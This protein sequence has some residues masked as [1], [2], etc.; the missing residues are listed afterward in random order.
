MKKL[1]F[2]LLAVSFAFGAAAF[3]QPIAMAPVA[4]QADANPPLMTLN[5]TI[6]ADGDK[7]T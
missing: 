2:T 3:A 4:V 7:Y 1:M 5:G 6:K